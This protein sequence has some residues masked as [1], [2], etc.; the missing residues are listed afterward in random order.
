MDR[1]GTGAASGVDRDELTLSEQERHPPAAGR[2]GWQRV[3]W[4]ALTL[5]V[6]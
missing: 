2:G 1:P 3:G 6:P 4:A 5:V